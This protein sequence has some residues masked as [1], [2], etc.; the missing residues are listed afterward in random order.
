LKQTF[1]AEAWE[2]GRF[3]RYWLERGQGTRGASGLRGV[4]LALRL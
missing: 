2:R 4:A 3:A 1:A